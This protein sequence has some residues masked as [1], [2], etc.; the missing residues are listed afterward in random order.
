MSL[1]L[2]DAFLIFTQAFLINQYSLKWSQD[3]NDI[4]KQNVNDVSATF[5][6][7]F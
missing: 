5:L 3:F 2:T 4:Q 6:Q 7:T 1:N